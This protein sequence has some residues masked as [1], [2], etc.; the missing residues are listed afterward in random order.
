MVAELQLRVIVMYSPAPRQVREI[1]VEVPA[2]AT[3]LQAL[4]ASG[5]L[6]EFP[7]LDAHES[8]AGV[9][10]R[11]ADPG[12]AVCDGDRI[13]LYRPL[14]V[15]PKFARRERFQQQGS[16]SAGLFAN[17]RPGSKAGY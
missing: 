9:W 8:A 6:Q 12:Q 4:V 15:D 5:L 1:Q 17:R 2:G 3:V 14:V 16:K 10:G 13:E 7:E 11:K